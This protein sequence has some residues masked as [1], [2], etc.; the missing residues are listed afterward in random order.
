MRK[1]ILGDSG[2]G[3]TSLVLRFITNEFKGTWSPPS[4]APLC[5]N[6][7]WTP[8]AR[9]KF[10][11]W[12]TAGQGGIDLAPMYY[13]GTAA[14]IVV[15]DITNEHSFKGASRGSRSSATCQPGYRADHRGQQRPRGGRRGLAGGGG[16]VRDS[17]GATFMETSAKTKSNTDEIFTNIPKARPS[18]R[19]LRAALSLPQAQRQ[20]LPILCC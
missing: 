19:A 14:A 20:E 7:S 11:T 2:V 4:A 13:R 8:T 16:G 3:K 17:I 12:D 10:E 18:L 6:S 15:Y 9:I 5:K 1:V